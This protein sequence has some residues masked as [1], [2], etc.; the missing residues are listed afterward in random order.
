MKVAKDQLKAFVER[1][2]RLD[3]SGRQ[4]SDDKRDIYAEAKANGFDVKALKAV[5]SYRRKDADEAETHDAIFRTYLDV[6][7]GKTT[8]GTDSATRAGARPD[9]KLTGA[10]TDPITPAQTFTAK[11][12][13]AR[14]PEIDLTIPA[15]LD[16]RSPA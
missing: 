9:P 13:P 5:I 11:P 10:A 14:A 2:E 12:I 8:T 16:R 3:E 6:L 7:T 15:F 4:I 1:I